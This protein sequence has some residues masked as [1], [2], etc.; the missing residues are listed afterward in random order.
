VIVAG[1]AGGLTNAL[2]PGSIFV[3]EAAETESGQ[4][5]ACA[6][7]LVSAL[8]EAARRLGFQPCGGMLLTARTLITHD[9]REYWAARG[10]VA[11]DMETAVLPPQ[12]VDF[13]SIRVI[14]DTPQHSIGAEWAPGVQRGLSLRL[15]REGIWL[16]GHAPRYALRAAHIARGALRRPGTASP[17]VAGR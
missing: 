11:A 7:E 1:L 14:L 9:R 8:G 2:P 4:V 16:A 15:L 3:P 12:V 6:P 13:A 17:F 10:F 5:R